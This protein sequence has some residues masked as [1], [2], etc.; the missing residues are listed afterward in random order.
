MWT[1]KFFC[2]IIV[3][4]FTLILVPAMFA[5]A[6]PTITAN[7]NPVLILFTEKSGTTTIQWD[8][9]ANH[10]NAQVWLSIDGGSETLFDG[11]SSG[12]R[13][14]TIQL[15]KTYI[16][17]LYTGSKSICWIRLQLQQ[18]ENS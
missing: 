8:A 3:F 1:T 6:A 11:D 2:R 13:T 4:V 9:E 17:K 12:V 10:P 15:A 5:I 14:A 16:F 7:P 18:R